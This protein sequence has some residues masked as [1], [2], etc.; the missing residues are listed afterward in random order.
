MKDK[1]LKNIKICCYV[2]LA[3]CLVWAGSM[4]NFLINDLFFLHNRLEFK[5]LQL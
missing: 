5:C 1:T 4:V 3:F 2:A